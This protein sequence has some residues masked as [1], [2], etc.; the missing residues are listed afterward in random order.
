MYSKMKKIILII[1]SFIAISFLIILPQKS[2][3][4]IEEISVVLSSDK[5][6]AL[7]LTVTLA[8]I[9]K[10]A[11]NKDKLTFYI[12]EKNIPEFYKK[13]I[14]SLQTIKPFKITYIDM[15]KK[16]IIP[17]H[18]SKPTYYRYFLGDLFPH[19]EKIIYLDSDL[20]VFKSLS[21]LWK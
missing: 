11:N 1:T 20:Y 21:S 12:L 2:S 5:N 7:G 9:L 6:Y 14:A 17:S 13:K 19:H 4:D 3:N 16:T 8:S 18:L 10:N 15:T